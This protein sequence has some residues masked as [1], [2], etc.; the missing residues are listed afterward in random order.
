[1]ASHR[2]FVQSIATQGARIMWLSGTCTVQKPPNS[3]AMY[4]L[5]LGHERENPSLDS[6]VA[7]SPSPALSIILRVAL[8]PTT[9]K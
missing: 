8:G 7:V 5:R 1:M 6:H 3:D 2:L 4:V 9:D